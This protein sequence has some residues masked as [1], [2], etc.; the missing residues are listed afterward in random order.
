MADGIADVAAELSLA[1]S[2]AAR[3]DVVDGGEWPVASHNFPPLAARRHRQIERE[4]GPVGHLTGV[5]ARAARVQVLVG[6]SAPDGIRAG[7]RVIDDGVVVGQGLP[8]RAR[9]GRI[10][11]ALSRLVIGSDQLDA[12]ILVGPRGELVARH[13]GVG[14]KHTPRRVTLEVGRWAS[15]TVTRA[16]WEE[17]VEAE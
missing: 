17:A 12:R 9:G 7:G 2:E 10:R 5:L 1:R 6:A 16:R 11:L 14:R 13:H 3:D 4:L 8:V 15:A